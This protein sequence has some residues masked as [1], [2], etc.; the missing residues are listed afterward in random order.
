MANIVWGGDCSLGPNFQ[1]KLSAYA[2][3]VMLQVANKK[4]FQFY[5]DVQMKLLNLYEATRCQLPTK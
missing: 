4:Y 5:S 3:E 2:T 1:L